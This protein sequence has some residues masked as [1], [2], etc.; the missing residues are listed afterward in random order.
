MRYQLKTI[1]EESWQR[2]RCLAILLSLALIAVI[3]LAV[4]AEESD[5]DSKSPA[6]KDPAKSSTDSP[7]APKETLIKR[8]KPKTDST[9]RVSPEMPPLLP[10]K[11]EREVPK[12]EDTPKAEKAPPKTTGPQSESVK[13]TTP[14]KKMTPEDESL[15]KSL[16]PNRDKS[17]GDDVERLERA[18]AGMREAQQRVEGKDAG[19]GT[20][21]IQS[22]V[23][24]DLDLIIEALQKPQSQPPQNQ[25]Q[26][27][28]QQDQQKQKQG[29]KQQSGK[30]Q[31][32]LSLQRRREMAQRQMQQQQKQSDQQQKQRDREK[33]PETSEQQRLK[34]TEK[35]QQERQQE[36]V[37]DVWGHLPPNVRA[38][39]LN[40][41]SEKYLPKYEDLVR[42]YYEALAEKNRAKNPGR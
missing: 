3:P 28:Q 9:E 11:T 16:D 20:Q 7:A 31:R 5:K 27:Q 39:L 41:F 34:K 21:D 29:K 19:I 12:S 8:K 25:N 38:E 10:K 4:T 26:D 24:K 33:S 40:V 2:T 32:K 14:G 36:M 37:K 23:V 17:E 13:S 35:T 15:L 6:A 22:R 42:R 18:I 1:A 30:K